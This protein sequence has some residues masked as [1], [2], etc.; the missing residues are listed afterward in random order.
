[1]KKEVF[2]EMTTITEMIYN[3]IVKNGDLNYEHLFENK[4][5]SEISVQLSEFGKEECSEIIKEFMNSKLKYLYFKEKVEGQRTYTFSVMTPQLLAFDRAYF[6]EKLLVNGETVCLNENIDE[7]VIDVLY[8]PYYYEAVVEL[9]DDREAESVVEERLKNAFGGDANEKWMA[10]TECERTEKGAF[11]LKVYFSVSPFEDKTLYVKWEMSQK[12]NVHT[13]FDEYNK[14]SLD[15]NGQP[16]GKDVFKNLFEDVEKSWVHVLRVGQA[17][18]NYGE[19]IEQNGTIHKYFFDVGL[20]LDKHVPMGAALDHLRVKVEKYFNNDIE[21]II[22]SHWH[23]DH[24]KG[25]FMLKNFEKIDWIAPYLD[26]EEIKHEYIKRLGC[27]IYSKKKLAKVPTGLN[28]IYSC[29]DIILFRGTNNSN[30]KGDSSAIDGRGFLLQLNSTLLPGDCSFTY[31]PDG[32]GEKPS[33]PNYKYKHFIFPHHGSKM[34]DTNHRIKCLENTIDTKVIVP[35]GY[36]TYHHPNENYNL[37]LG[38][39]FTIYP[40]NPINELHNCFRAYYSAS[41]RSDEVNV[42]SSNPRIKTENKE[43]K[44]QDK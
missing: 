40:T 7:R 13:I 35:T 1:M 27:Y 20:P 34:D 23:T 17:S 14:K 29:G 22:L 8:K 38:K 32:F 43:F 18:A 16:L 41:A 15:Y 42:I 9:G 36:N 5:E 31:W 12:V 24:V 39:Q 26:L 33:N 37:F 10:I 30:N 6:E 2:K 21:T 44:I 19:A 3:Y 11:P 25:A 4:A 28:K